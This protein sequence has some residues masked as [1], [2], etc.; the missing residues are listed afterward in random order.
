MSCFESS[1]F[2]KN[3]K[4]M[5]QKVLKKAC[6][7][8]GWKYEIRQN[9]FVILNTNSNVNLHGEYALKVVG[10]KVTYNSYYMKNGRELVAQ[11]EAQF[12]TLNIEYAKST[13]IE[14]FES[15]G[16][17]FKKNYDFVASAD[18]VD[19]FYMVGYSR[20]RKETEKRT[21]IKFT[22]LKD[23]TIVSDSN[24]IPEDVHKLADEAMESIDAA[25]GTQRREG[26]EIKRKEI[27]AKYKHKA[28]CNAQNKIIA[29]N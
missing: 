9:E 22:I 23:G 20:D 12:Y 13:I 28:Y 14:A 5:N 25:F 26:F 4:V 27:P 8:L 15:K 11:L 17:N 6:D 7:K 24:Y 10:N 16:F 19:S 3:P 29:K 21:E 1:T 18:E 2:L